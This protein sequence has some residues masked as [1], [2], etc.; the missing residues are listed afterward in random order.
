MNVTND[1][2]LLTVEAK[3]PEGAFIAGFRWFRL[4]RF[5]TIELVG[6]DD[7]RWVFGNTWLLS[8]VVKTSEG[9]TP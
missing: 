5:T 7:A 9:A 2:R 3:D 6:F 8:A 1:R 4:N